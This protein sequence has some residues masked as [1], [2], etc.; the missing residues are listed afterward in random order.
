[1]PRKNPPLASQRKNPLDI[2]RLIFML[3]CLALPV[4][5]YLA[6]GHP[7]FMVVFFS[8]MIAV[9]VTIARLSNK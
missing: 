1:M 3:A 6:T 2:G 7:A 9:G 8:G 4:L 5:F